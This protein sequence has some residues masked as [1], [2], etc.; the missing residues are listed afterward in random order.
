MAR[1]FILKRKIEHK[2]F[3]VG[4]KFGKFSVSEAR[5]AL[6]TRFFKSYDSKVYPN[7]IVKGNRRFFPTELI[8]Q[9]F[10]HFFENSAKFARDDREHFNLIRNVLR[11]KYATAKRYPKAA[12]FNPDQPRDD[13]GRWVDEAIT[14][15]S[16]ANE[17]LITARKEFTTANRR[18]V[19]GEKYLRLENN[20]KSAVRRLAHADNLADKTILE[21]LK[22]PGHGDGMSTV[23]WRQDPGND[24]PQLPVVNAAISA[25]D[26]VNQS[27]ISIPNLLIESTPDAV[28]GLSTANGRNHSIQLDHFA[29]FETTLH[30]VGHHFE[31]NSLELNTAAHKFITERKKN[32]FFSSRR[33]EIEN[34]FLLSYAAKQ[35]PFDM[36]LPGVRPTEVVSVGFER[37]FSSPARFAREDPEYFKFVRGIFK[38]KYAQKQ[39]LPKAA[40]DVTN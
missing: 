14:A 17:A 15:A 30:E 9:G 26:A 4:D 23:T 24:I 31:F 1:D 19:Y 2:E 16:V 13:H 18:G 25:I 37:F 39:Q 28:H 8:S 5:G 10:S 29:G 3:T 22:R 38:G 33:S 6:L 11:G 20:L 7:E 12:E 27:G 36:G 32:T 35:Y 21:S 40:Q 34:K